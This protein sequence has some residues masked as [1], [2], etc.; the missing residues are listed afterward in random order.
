MSAVHETVA[1]VVKA[2]RMEP[3]SRRTFAKLRHSSRPRALRGY[4]ALTWEEAN[5]R[6]RALEKW[7]RKQLKRPKA[8]NRAVGWIGIETYKL[9][10]RLAVTRGGKLDTLAYGSIAGLLGVSKSAVVAAMARLRDHGW[11]RWVRTFY[12][13]GEAG[14]RGPQVEQAP[15]HYW[16][17]APLAALAKIGIRFRPRIPDDDLERR[18]EAEATVKRQDLAASPLGGVLDRFGAAIAERESSKASHSIDD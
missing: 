14:V 4:G 3:E 7:E 5:E 16:I 8:K 18:R 11:I 2:R 17:E 12:E 15:N 10:C 1:G 13:T 9:M 6:M